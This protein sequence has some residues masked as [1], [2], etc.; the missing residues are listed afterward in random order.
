MNSTWSVARWSVFGLSVLLTATGI[1]L[2]IAAGGGLALGAGEL[3]LP[4]SGLIYAGLGALVLSRHPRHPIGWLLAGLGL[5]NSI[6]VLNVGYLAYLSRALPGGV[7]SV[8]DFALWSLFW[9]HVPRLL[10]PLTLLL[11]L[12]PDG[13]LLSRRWRAILWAAALGLVISIV[14]FAFTT[15][16]SERIGVAITNPFGV[17]SQLMTAAQAVGSLLAFVGLIGALAA[18]TVRFRRSRGVER[19]QMK[20][21]TYAMVIL[22]GALIL[23]GG[24]AVA[25]PEGT[26][27]LALFAAFQLLAAISIPVAA[28][29]AILRY[30]L[31]DIDLIIN[32]SLVYSALTALVVGLYVLVVGSLSALFQT[33]R[34]LMISL[35]ATGLIAVLFQPMRDRL[36]RAVNRAL[37]GRRDEP[38][39]VLS[40]LGQQLEEPAAPEAMLGSIVET[41]ART[42]KLPFVAIALPE[43]EGYEIASEYG[44]EDAG[45]ITLPLTYR[46]VSV[47]QLICSPRSPTEQFTDQEERLLRDIAN[48]AAVAV[49]ALNLSAAL[50]RSREQ[51]VSAREEERRRLRRDL[52]DGLGPQLASLALKLDAARNQLKNDP[53]LAD[54]ILMQLRWDAQNAL[55]DIR[56]LVYN[57]RPPV[58]DEL[59]LISAL[60]ASAASQLSAPGPSIVVEGPESLPALP[61][62]VEVAAYRIAQEAVNNVV[63]HAHAQRCTVRLHLTDGLELEVLD[64]GD[65]IPEAYKPGVGL[66]SMKER[67]A[68]L[69]GQF[70]F[71]GVPEGGARVV[72]R[73]PLTGQET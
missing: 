49:H 1:L 42:L 11:L 38:Y 16:P 70:K 8:P 52:H 60:R 28:S 32:R 35:V 51:L 26:L 62:A 41:V 31:Y 48:Q 66:N 33:Q 69:G 50:Q 6:E 18:V 73:F 65:G 24:L 22:V 56:R 46:G 63:R 55:A 37:Y 58:L 47:G 14:S 13:E 19:Q 45:S 53:K 57:L 12:F 10:V 30:R 71:E 17:E 29:V 2:V 21:I 3:V 25:S 59:G 43:A 36:Q 61:A 40:H 34:S 5:I 23:A 67:T 44:R 39:D 54:S 68:E 4:I 20:W 72:A 64:D 9:V 7:S 27:P 15:E